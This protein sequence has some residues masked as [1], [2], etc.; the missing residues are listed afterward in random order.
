MEGAPEGPLYVAAGGPTCAGFAVPAAR[1]AG[2][3]LV[4][5]S[6]GRTVGVGAS[7]ASAGTGPC[8]A[9]AVTGGGKFGAVEGVEG[10]APG[11]RRELHLPG[12]KGMTRE[13]LRG[14]GESTPT[15]ATLSSG[16]KAD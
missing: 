14:M 5:E 8:V 16:R 9:V 15:L 10:A 7:G 12:L 13:F 1:V 4:K 2:G 3:G 11:L 6:D